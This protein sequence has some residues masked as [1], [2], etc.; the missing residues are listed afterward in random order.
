MPHSS[1]GVSSS[2]VLFAGRGRFPR[3]VIKLVVRFVVGLVIGLVDV[4]M[5]S[6]PLSLYPE[7]AKK[8]LP[9]PRKSEKTKI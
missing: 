8:F 3:E 7:T 9:C 6:V 5:P 2:Q 4:A 1:W